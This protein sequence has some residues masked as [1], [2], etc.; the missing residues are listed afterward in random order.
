MVSR[1]IP[2]EYLLSTVDL[3]LSKE[4]RRERRSVGVEFLSKS[5]MFMNIKIN[6]FSQKYRSDEFELMLITLKCKLQ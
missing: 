5:S 2:L 3:S 4:R 6:N 1:K